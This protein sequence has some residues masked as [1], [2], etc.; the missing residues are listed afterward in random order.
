MGYRTF[1]QLDCGNDHTTINVCKSN[2]IIHLQLKN[3]IAF[4][5][6]LSKAG[7]LFVLSTHLRVQQIQSQ[8]EAVYKFQAIQIW[9]FNP[10]YDLVHQFFPPNIHFPCS[11]LHPTVDY[12]VA[13]EV[14]VEINRGNIRILSQIIDL[15]CCT[16]LRQQQPL[17]NAQVCY[18]FLTQPDCSYYLGWFLPFQKNQEYKRPI[19]H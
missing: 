18:K 14:Q 17:E 2:W 3:C 13:T 10:P 8:L 4:K 9:F 1:S 7:L 6:Y 15:P 19:P 5:F 16:Q 12:V 11:G